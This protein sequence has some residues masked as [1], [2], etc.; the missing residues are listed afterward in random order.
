MHAEVVERTEMP[1]VEARAESSAL[2]QRRQNLEVI[3]GEAKVF[4]YSPA[5]NWSGN[6]QIKVNSQDAGRISA[7][8]WTCLAV[9]AGTDQKLQVGRRTLVMD[10]HEGTNYFIA[11]VGEENGRVDLQQTENFRMGDRT[12]SF[13]SRINKMFKTEC[14]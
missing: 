13:D 14:W 9:G 1:A 6:G 4:L 8:E 10:T 11:I 3:P 5:L 2:F 12:L 7:G